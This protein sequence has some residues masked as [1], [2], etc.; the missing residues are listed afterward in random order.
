MDNSIDK[1]STV[2]SGD[3]DSNYN[4][5]EKTTSDKLLDI[6]HVDIIKKVIDNSDNN[7]V[8]GLII[9]N[10]HY[11]SI[12]LSSNRARKWLQY[13]Y[14]QIN[15]KTCSSEQCKDI[16]QIASS[17][18]IFNHSSKKEII[19]NRIAMSNGMIYYDMCTSDWKIIKI[20]SESWEII[21]MDEETPIFE[22]KQQQSEQVAPTVPLDDYDPLEEMCL[23]LKIKQADKM[24][25]KIHIVAFFIEKY[26]IPIMVFTGEHGSIKTTIMQTV[27]NIVDP[28]MQ[29]SSRLHKKMEDISIHLYNRY[30]SG[31]D[32]ISNF[33][34]DISDLLCR[35]ITGEGDSK[36]E[37]YTNM[38]EIIL[39]YKRKI[40]ING[41]TPS[42]EYPDLL[43]RSIFY[44]TGVITRHN[45][46]TIEEFVIKRNNIMPYLM[47]QIFDV[48]RAALFI[49]STVK[50][51]LRGKMQR[52]SDFSI[53][54]EAISRAMGIEKMTFIDTYT[55]RIKIDSLNIVNSYPI[56]EIIQKI[57]KDIPKYEDTI[58]NFYNFIKNHA[59]ENDVDIK[60][61]ESK[62]PKAPHMV[63]MQID[64]LRPTF[65]EL[66]FD[67]VMSRNNTFNKEKSWNKGVVIIRIFK[68]KE[69][70]L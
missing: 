30:L 52:M 65:R 6:I 15:H 42:L 54:G 19:H 38:D 49:H 60:S 58:S 44:Q 23:L 20:S 68:I 46:L 51:D 26:P 56:F 35:V 67:I 47:N 66:G 37:L 34:Q 18:V 16:L 50:I 48:L 14:Y 13:R 5:E 40:I 28:S 11:E 10:G 24:I 70:V 45:R 9:I 62:F 63:K 53:W 12:L 4:N 64:I 21:P 1:T 25:F 22:R 41:I 7:K 59:I 3:D 27:K 43:D 57:M 29:L 39:N 2:Y 55:E 8:Y 33:N 31:F 32:N 61:R 36:R 69:S 17:E